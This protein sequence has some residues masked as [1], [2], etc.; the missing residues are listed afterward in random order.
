MVNH[1]WLAGLKAGDEVVL[2]VAY[3]SPSIEVVLRATPTTLWVCLYKFR[4]ADGKQAGPIELRR[5]SIEEPTIELR[6][7]IAQRVLAGNLSVHGWHGERLDTLRKVAA[8]LA[9]APAKKESD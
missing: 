2:N 6:N 1:E 5:A 9:R 3:D 8:I 4:R 7:E